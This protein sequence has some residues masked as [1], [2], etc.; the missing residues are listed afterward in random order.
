[1]WSN[2]SQQTTQTK[3]NL[4]EQ[5][6]MCTYI[7]KKMS[8]VAPLQDMPGNPLHPCQGSSPDTRVGKGKVIPLLLRHHKIAPVN[9]SSVHNPCA[10]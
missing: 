7:Q 8:I 9:S 3:Y 2:A 5:I 10:L 1:M 6:L 4:N